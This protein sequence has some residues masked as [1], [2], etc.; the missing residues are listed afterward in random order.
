MASS[1][2]LNPSRLTELVS[3]P[4]LAILIVCSSGCRNVREGRGTLPPPPP[5]TSSHD[6]IANPFTETTPGVFTRLEYRTVASPTLGIEI[7]DIEV[8]PLTP[9]AALSFPGAGVLAVR[10]GRASGRLL[11]EDLEVAIGGTLAMSQGDTLHLLRIG[12]TPLSLR[13]YVLGS[14]ESLTRGTR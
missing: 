1:T 5:G 4:L 14:P 13:V 9:S 8:A 10:A 7:W 11:G 12:A 2:D 3:G 6:S